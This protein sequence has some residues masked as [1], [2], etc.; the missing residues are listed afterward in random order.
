MSILFRLEELEGLN[1]TLKRFDSIEF[2]TFWFP[3]FSHVPSWRK[4]EMKCWLLGPWWNMVDICWHA[5]D[6]VNEVVLGTCSLSFWG[7][8]GTGATSPEGAKDTNL[9]S[10]LWLFEGI[11]AFLYLFSCNQMV[12]FCSLILMLSFCPG[13]A[14]AGWVGAANPGRSSMHFQ[15]KKLISCHL[16][17]IGYLSFRFWCHWQVS[18]DVLSMMRN[19]ILE[20]NPCKIWKFLLFS[21]V[22]WDREIWVLCTD[23]YIFTSRM[24]QVS[25]G[26]LL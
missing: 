25:D 12:L 14:G 11:C 19:V 16:Y 8:T 21:C 9:H 1:S 5:W 3:I 2:L 7:S 24:N 10:K 23:G 4:K 26:N 18:S 6:A 20:Q 15:T 13:A 22:E 17:C